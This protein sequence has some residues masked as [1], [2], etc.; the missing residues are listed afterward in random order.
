MTTASDTL[1]S[2]SVHRNQLVIA[3]VTNGVTRHLCMLDRRMKPSFYLDNGEVV[4][5]DKQGKEFTL[6]TSDSDAEKLL[7]QLVFSKQ[8]KRFPRSAL[9]WALHLAVAGGL[10]ASG[11]VTAIYQNVHQTSAPLVMNSAPVP[12]AAPAIGLPKSASAVPGQIASE[13]KLPAQV[14]TS[15]RN[16]AERKHF[17]VDYS[18][19]HARTLYV[20][21]DPACPNCQ[22]VEPLLKAA[23]TAV[24]VVVFPVA[25]FG[26]EK[27][28]AS[29][30]PVLCLPPEQRKAAWDALFD[31]GRDGLTLGNA[32]ASTTA[33][34]A[35]ACVDGQR[36]LGINEIAYRAYRIP[37]TPWVIADDGRHVSQSLLGDPAKLAE[38]LDGKEVTDAAE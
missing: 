1:F 17:T 27:S 30:S 29:V 21:A 33:G 19:G 14:Q 5:R 38:F 13:W 3:E 18:S 36:A 8:V 20:F 25:V 34:N 24:N 22:R 10:I 15:L 31:V 28:I 35:G 12:P 7:A 26:K 2:V 4:C 37:G 32:D 9:R 23:S 11:Y 16:A 6:G